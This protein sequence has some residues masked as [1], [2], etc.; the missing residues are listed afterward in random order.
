MIDPNVASALKYLSSI[1]PP[2]G[3][4]LVSNNLGAF[5]GSSTG[6]QFSNWDLA[7]QNYKITGFIGMMMFDFVFFW[8]LGWYLEN[9]LPHEWGVKRSVCF[10]FTRRYWCSSRKRSNANPLVRGRSIVKESVVS[11][12]EED[13]ELFEEVAA[14]LKAQ[15]AEGECLTIRNLQK[16]YSNGKKAV[17][18][19]N[20]EMYNG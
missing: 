1:A 7:Y 9:V 5:E 11:N 13:H 12:T 19:L 14:G 10:C 17:N 16:T 3:I 2:I 20:V 4:S 15:E 8:L 6:T 18:G